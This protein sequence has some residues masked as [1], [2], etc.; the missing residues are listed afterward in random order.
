MKLNVY[1]LIKTRFSRI[2]LISLWAF[3]VVFCYQLLSIKNTVFSTLQLKST[4]LFFWY[5]HKHVKMP[6][7]AKRIVIVALDENS[8]NKILERRPL[9]RSIYADFLEKISSNDSAPLVVG[10]DFIFTSNTGRPEI[11]ALFNQ[12]LKKSGNA[13]IADY[14]NSSGKLILP[15]AL[16]LESAR[17]AG[18]INLPRD[19][20]FH[21]RRAYLLKTSRD[22]EILDYSFFF[23]VFSLVQGFDI[24][25]V[26][27]NKNNLELTLPLGRTTRKTNSI[28]L[29]GKDNTV[30]VNYFGVLNDFK[31]VSLW[32]VLNSSVTAEAFKDKIVLFGPTLESYQDTHPTALGLMPGVAVNANL[33][34]TLLSERF[35]KNMPDK[36][37]FL[38]L[39]IACFA[40]TYA[41][42]K[43]KNIASFLV[44]VSIIATG[45][46]IAAKQ[47]QKDILFDF[48]GLSTVCIF[49]YICIYSFKYV[50]VLIEKR[51]LELLAITDGLTG[52][53]ILR[54][55]EVKLNSEIGKAI[56]NNTS[57][58]LAIFD[59]DHF[60][61]F[62]DNYGHELG[63]E[64]LKS[65]ASILKKNSRPTDQVCRFGGEE[66]VVILPYTKLED[67]VRY[68][69]KIRKLIEAFD[70]QWKDTTLKI[71]IS[72][73]VSALRNS[74]NSYHLL[75]E[76]ADKALYVAKESGRN[77]VC[78]VLE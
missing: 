60:K 28:R 37:N 53:Y 22:G 48:F 67:G 54:Y 76:T 42:A 77:R 64:V 5:R 58:S 40:V 63:N 9:D 49:S 4:D 12:A 1:D 35:V 18:F 57:L 23:N 62:N 74:V 17:L 25:N 27:Y 41:V 50:A 75:L 32:N 68:A 30:K 2:F 52:L 21:I 36:I 51:N 39:F 34:L 43:L 78:T 70:L 14:F 46:Y 47:M 3:L 56:K 20:D 69:E 10:I 6:E 8:Y 61:K 44:I 55:F 65:V 59:I 71:T 7:E 29:D 72:A 33:L 19:S 73:G 16:L 66:F 13:V 15:D 26:T 31:T 38:I 11:D 45:F 24:E